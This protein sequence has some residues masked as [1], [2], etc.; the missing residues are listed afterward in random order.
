MKLSLFHMIIWLS[1]SAVAL[2]SYGFW[3][4]AIANKSND[5]AS[6]QNQIDTKVNMTN[7]IASARL[8]LAEIAGDEAIIR[9]YFIPETGV[10]S[11]ID[12]LEARSRAQAATTKVFSVSTGGT[13]KQPILILALTVSGTF[14][15]VMRT[16]GAIE[17]A[18][19]DLSISK[20]SLGKDGKGA[21][22]SDLE[23]IVGSV[24]KSV[25][26]STP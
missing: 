8:A 22:H 25:A 17:Y 7:R 20:L 23:L 5:V 13:D 12:D 16:V 3:Y 9:G 6:L 14:D 18:P 1:I 11:F 10:V 4:A 21:W 26:T 2:V 19:Y 15:A 24:P